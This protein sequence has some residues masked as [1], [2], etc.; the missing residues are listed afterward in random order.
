MGSKTAPK[1][2]QKAHEL[3]ESL[4]EAPGS[5]NTPKHIG[6]SMNFA[7]SPFRLRLAS[8]ASAWPEYGPTELQISQTRHHAAPKMPSRDPESP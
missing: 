5:Q 1:A 8:E 3:P 7:C 6:N 2:P 4:H